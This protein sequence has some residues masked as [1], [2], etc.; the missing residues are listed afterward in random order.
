MLLGCCVVVCVAIV[1][2]VVKVVVVDAGVVAQL[3]FVV[4]CGQY[5]TSTVFPEK[6]TTNLLPPTNRRPAND[7]LAAVPYTI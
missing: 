1:V 7:R 5:F 3:H 4:T 2:I 6:L